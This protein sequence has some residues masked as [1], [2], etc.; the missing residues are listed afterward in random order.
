M[1]WSHISTNE[2]LSNEFSRNHPSSFRPRLK[3]TVTHAVMDAN[4]IQISDIESH[5]NNLI[6][7]PV[8]TKNSS[9]PGQEH[10]CGVLKLETI[11]SGR[12]VADMDRGPVVRG[13]RGT[14]SIFFV[15]GHYHNI[16]RP[17]I[18][19]TDVQGGPRRLAGRGA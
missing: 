16:C 6:T 12:S 9:P 3:S 11:S 19:S 18:D 15:T 13:H 17:P 14:G 1:L 7:P 4:I 5:Q 2:Y 10:R 8:P